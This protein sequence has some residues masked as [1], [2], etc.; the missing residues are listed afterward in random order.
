M[1]GIFGSDSP[2][3]QIHLLR[4]IQEFLSSQEQPDAPVE[5]VK[6]EKGIKIAELVGNVDGFADSG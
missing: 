5:K 4:V 3:A 6:V 1:D 2:P